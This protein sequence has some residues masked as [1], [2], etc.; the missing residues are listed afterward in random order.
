MKNI[1][2]YG[3]LKAYK[4]INKIMKQQRIHRVWNRVLK[5]S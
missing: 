1:I 4:R 2:M 3:A 5:E